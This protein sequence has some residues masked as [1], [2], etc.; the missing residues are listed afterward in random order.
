MCAQRI[1]LAAVVATLL[2]A[3]PAAHA[4]AASAMSA[5]DRTSTDS[6]PNPFLTPVYAVDRPASIYPDENER[7]LQASPDDAARGVR[8]S[9]DVNYMTDYVF[10]GIDRSEVGSIDPNDVGTAAEDAPNLQFDGRLS[11]DLGRLPHPFIG[12]F[13]NVYNDD[14]ISRFQEVRPYFG[15]DWNLRPVTVTAGWQ[16]FIF[17]ERDDFN[18]AEVFMQVKLND[19][20]LWGNDDKNPILSPYVYAAWDHDLYDGVYIEAGVRHDFAFEGTNFTLSVLADVAFVAGHAY[21]TRANGEDTG[22]QHYD[23]GLIGSYALNVPLNIP[24]RFGDWRLKGYLFY[25]DNINDDL[26]ADTQI[27]GGVGIGFSY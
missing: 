26:R 24:R 27:W 25:T 16:T 18:T 8:L 4:S 11:F 13:V 2:A 1:G 22:F 21:F 3:A 14:P 9:L 7:I 20:F 19:A 12:A 15:F 6:L 5:A 23:V 17:P 10:R